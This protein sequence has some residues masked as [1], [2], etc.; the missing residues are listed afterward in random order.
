VDALGTSCSVVALLGGADTATAANYYPQETADKEKIL[1]GYDRLTY[2][3]DNWVKETTICG[4]GSDN[5]Y[6]G[7]ERNP[8]KVMEVSATPPTEQKHLVSC[9][10]NDLTGWFYLY[11]V[12]GL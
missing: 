4:S 3:L 6:I 8:M 10:L 12:F 1:K 2:L 7:C 9:K 5:P 11:L